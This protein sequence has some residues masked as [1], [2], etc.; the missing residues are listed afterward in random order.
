[1]CVLGTRRPPGSRTRLFTM[2]RGLLRKAKFGI[3]LPDP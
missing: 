2:T 1:M 3:A